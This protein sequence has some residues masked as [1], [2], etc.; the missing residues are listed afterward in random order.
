MKK[1]NTLA[2]LAAALLSGWAASAV[3]GTT[4]ILN[5]ISNPTTIVESYSGTN[6][7]SSFFGSGSYWG[8]DVGAPTYE[9]TQ[10]VAS[11][12]NAGHG[13]VTLTFTTGFSSTGGSQ[14]IGGGNTVYA[15]DIF[16]KSGA[17][18][19]AVS[20]ALS[21]NWG[22]ALGKDGADGGF[23]SPGLYSNTGGLSDYTSQHVWSGVGGVDY[24]GAFAAA[25]T[26]T[27][28]SS[29]CGASDV[30]PTVIKSTASGGNG[31]LDSNVAVSENWGAT[32]LTVTLTGQN[33]AGGL[34]LASIFSSF[35]IFWGTGD[36]SNA[37]IWGFVQNLTQ[38]PEPSSL[39]LLVSAAFGF[40]LLRRRRRFNVV[41]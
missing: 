20:S 32:A 25:G 33:A 19:G 1:I 24:G 8:A 17:T 18:S 41:A 37:P 40:A 34:D 6:P 15:A 23:S 30:S 5:P 38:V 13:T 3:A 11:Y 26:C 21:F 39:A 22:I 2:A 28:T 14:Q 4:T 16:L 36:C 9:T 35:D 7:T 29:T 27:V 12:S 10:L 31:T